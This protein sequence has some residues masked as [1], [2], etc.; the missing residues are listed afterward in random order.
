MNVYKK[1]KCYSNSMQDGQYLQADDDIVETVEFLYVCHSGLPTRQYFPARKYFKCQYR[2]YRQNDITQ[3]VN[4]PP[5]CIS[6]PE[7]IHDEIL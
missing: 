1:K 5:C 7:I 3:N 6:I 4:F 2:E